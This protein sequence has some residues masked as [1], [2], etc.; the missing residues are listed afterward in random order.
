MTGPVAA[1]KRYIDERMAGDRD[2][3]ASTVTCPYRK[4]ARVWLA[5]KYDC[6]AFC[7]YLDSSMLVGEKSLGAK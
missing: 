5:E 1:A 2:A 6:Q 4:G 3:L 7:Q